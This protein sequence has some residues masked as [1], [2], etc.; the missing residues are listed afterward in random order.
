MS[1][2]STDIG[3]LPQAT[4]CT[5]GMHSLC[6]PPAPP[7]SV[8]LRFQFPCLSLIL[9][10]FIPIINVADQ[11]VSESESEVTL[12][13]GARVKVHN[14]CTV[15]TYTHSNIDLIHTCVPTSSNASIQPSACSHTLGTLGIY[16][17]VMYGVVD[18]SNRKPEVS[19]PMILVPSLFKAG[20]SSN[21][22]R[23]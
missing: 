22:S 11:C 3:E 21:R 8:D 17:H 1:D 12:E 10:C 20:H 4:K 18:S 2:A 23:G 16:G 14:I 13:Y 7:S 19:I 9:T 15:T 6:V 5:S